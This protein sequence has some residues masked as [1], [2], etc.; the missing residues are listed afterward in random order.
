[1]ASRGG[2]GVVVLSVVLGILALAG[3]VLSIVFYGQATTAREQ[4]DAYKRDAQAFIRDGERNSDQFREMLLQAGQANSSLASFLTAQFR[5]ISS[6]VSGVDQETP[7]S[8]TDK[9]NSAL[10]PLGKSNLLQAVQELGGQVLK[11]QADLKEADAAR[12]GAVDNLSVAQDRVKAL[13]ESHQETIK[14]L[15]SAVDTY[16]GQVESYQTDL[17][18]SA[19]EMRGAVDKI[20]RDAS[21]EAARLNDRITRLTDELL[22]A[23]GKIRSLQAARGKE[24]LKPGDEATL[25]DG[26]IVALV[27]A[28]NT[29]F[30][31]R[32]K[33]QRMVLGMS[34]EVYSDAAAIKLEAD[35]SYSRG[36]AS[37]EVIR[38]D[39][40]SSTA[41]IVRTTRGNPIARGDVIVNPVYDPTKKYNFLVFGNFDTDR[42][43]RVTPGEADDIRAVIVG[44]G[45]GLTDS[46]TGD[47][48][49]VVLGERPLVPPAPPSDAAVEF[50][51]RFIRAR[52]AAEQY[53]RLL[54]QASSTSIP[55][56]NQN[57]LMTLIGR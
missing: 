48:D 4:L 15:G 54:E 52:R 56:L 34:F 8:L 10:E 42:D 44:W 55:L 53:D 41:R 13:E 25:V 14:T 32:G 36:K 2:S 18:K 40:N 1:M 49:F 57:R 12:Q 11:A 35:G 5:Q 20:K 3:F 47:V 50:V 43:G 17:S 45:G 46:L 30:I 7:K 29:V 19:E 21:D 9:I 37:V 24:S 22:V 23:Q 38:V 26:E 51:D 33:N 28:D 6:K 31:N 27:D 39:E 16:K